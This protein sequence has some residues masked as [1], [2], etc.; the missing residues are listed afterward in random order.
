MYCKTFTQ[1]YNS[2]GITF[3][4]FFKKNITLK[5]VEIFLEIICFHVYFLRSYNIENSLNYFRN[6]E[7]I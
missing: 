3:S 4:Y 7:R 2:V 6:K 5:S 1:C